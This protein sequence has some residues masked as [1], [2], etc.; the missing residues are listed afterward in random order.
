M[1]NNV[2]AR[3]GLSLAELSLVLM[4]ASVFIAASFYS[5]AKIR[6]A[7]SGQRVIEELDSIAAASTRY[8]SEHGAWPTGLSDLRPSYLVQQSSD[9]NPFG[10]A[11]TITSNALSFLV[12]T[13]LPKGLITNKSYGSEVVVVNQGNNDL[14]SITKSPE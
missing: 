12:S 3:R 1:D 13:L 2:L 10:N 4:V 11:Y 5:A 14:V 9:V 8:Y 7:A 6:Q